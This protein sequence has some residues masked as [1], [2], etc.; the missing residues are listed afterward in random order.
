MCDECYALQSL[1]RI[2]QNYKQAAESIRAGK[3]AE[4]EGRGSQAKN[5]YVAAIQG[6][7]QIGGGET[8]AHVKELA[9]RVISIAK[10]GAKRNGWHD[11][12]AKTDSKNM[13]GVQFTEGSG[14]QVAVVARGAG[15]GGRAHVTGAAVGVKTE[16]DVN[17]LGSNF[18]VPDHPWARLMYY[19][20]C[21]HTCS[22]GFPLPDDVKAYRT[23]YNASTQT[24]YAVVKWCRKLTPQ[25]M[26]SQKIFMEANNPST[27][28][29]CPN[30]FYDVKQSAHLIGL[31]TVEGGGDAAVVGQDL[32][33]A[34]QLRHHMFFS[35]SFMNQT[36]YSPIRHSEIT[37]YYQ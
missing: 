10:A 32:G 30:Y 28:K 21:I 29:G 18:D 4:R 19:L 31:K 12:S 6:V 33:T 9:G 20:F 14:A 35:A 25:Y 23:Y 27:L 7:T 13:G 16:V 11:P 1:E 17:A 15:A 22:T 24:K 34:S 37:P 5:L 8:Q 3:R 2:N 26:E 36:Y